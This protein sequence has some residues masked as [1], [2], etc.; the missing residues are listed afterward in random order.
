MSNEKTLSDLKDES[1][2]FS[3]DVKENWFRFEDELYPVLKRGTVEEAR[4]KTAKM[5]TQAEIRDLKKFGN[6]ISEGTGISKTFIFGSPV[7]ILGILFLSWQFPDFLKMPTWLVWMFI[8]TIPM[9]LAT[10]IAFFFR[11]KRDLRNK[12]LYDFLNEWF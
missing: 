5:F 11:K 12:I 4:T 1:P 8:L 6:Y 7:I 9:I 3:D 2:E 10:I